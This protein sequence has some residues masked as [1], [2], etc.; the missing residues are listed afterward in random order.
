MRLRFL[1]QTLEMARPKKSNL[2]AS[3]PLDRKRLRL[4]RPFFKPSGEP[5]G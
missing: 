5:S 4:V 3:A 2:R 1:R